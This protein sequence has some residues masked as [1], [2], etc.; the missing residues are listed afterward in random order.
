[1]LGHVYTGLYHVT[2]PLMLLS[3]QFFLTEG[4]EVCDLFQ[5]LSHHSLAEVCVSG[6]DQAMPTVQVEFAPLSL[7]ISLPSG[8]VF[9]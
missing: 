2:V 1:M 8:G 5:D 7:L 4:R 9:D 6:D 3:F